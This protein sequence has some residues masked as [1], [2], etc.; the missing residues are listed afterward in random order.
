MKYTK[1]YDDND[2]DNLATTLISFNKKFMGCFIPEK[3]SP[4]VQ[5]ELRVRIKRKNVIVQL[6]QKIF[7]T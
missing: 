6:F 4:I 1:W 7:K 3:N 2:L 5:L